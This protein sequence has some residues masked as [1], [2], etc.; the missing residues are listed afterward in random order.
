MAPVSVRYITHDVDACVD[1]YT[2]H[3]GFVVEMRP[4]PGF[5][6]L[7]RG[8]LRLLLSAPGAGGGGLATEEVGVSSPGWNRVQLVVSDLDDV[9]AALRDGGVEPATGV[10]DGR[11]GR[12]SLV[13]DPTGNLIEL[14]E[15]A[16]R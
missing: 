7:S 6:M 11:G 2:A 12:T 4:A 15:P 5:A 8:G 14:F 13:R 16:G 10:V 3:L 1:F 9:V